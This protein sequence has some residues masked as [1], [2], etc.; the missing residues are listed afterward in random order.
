PGLGFELVSDRECRGRWSVVVEWS[1][2]G[3][4]VG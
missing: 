3:E 2:S 1:R 4:K